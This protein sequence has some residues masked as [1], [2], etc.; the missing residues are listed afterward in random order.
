MNILELFAGSRSIGKVAEQMGMNVFSVDWENYENIDLVKDIE[1]LET[2]DIPFVPDMVWASPDCTSYSIS[3][4]SHHRNGTEPKSDYAKKCDITNQNFIS[5]IKKWLE[6]NPNMVFFIENPRG[7]LRKMPWMQE[8][9]RHTIWYCFSKETK[10]ITDVGSVD[11]KSVENTYQ[12]LLMIDGSWKKCIIRNYGKQ[13]LYKIIFKRAGNEHIIFSTK[14]HKWIIELHSGRRVIVNTIGLKKG[15]RIPTIYSKQNFSH[16]DED[17][18]RSGF[19]YG[20]GYANYKKKGGKKIPYDSVAQFC[21]KKDEELIKFF[22]GLGRSRRYNK[23]YLNISGL[24]FDW[25]K[26]IPNI[27]NYSKEYIVGWLS[28]Y[29]AA[30]GTVGKNGQ[31]TMYSA[32]KNNMDKFKDLCQ[33]VGIGTYFVNEWERDG[34]GKKRKIYSLGL[35]RSTIPDNFILMSHHR[36]NNFTPKFEPHW[37]VFSI[38]ETDRFEDVYCAEVEDYESFV[39]DGNILTHNCKYGDDRAKPT[40]I[41]T[42]SKTWI[43]RPVC[44]NGNPDCHH[45]RAPRGSKTGTQGRKG[46]YERSKIPNELCFEILKSLKNEK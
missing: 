4:I 33:Y 5:L 1:Y 40:D 42:N 6:I 11:I 7:M 27:Y 16:I 14:N 44:K 10:I 21:G 8:F 38:E 41:W 31:V 30:D 15:D 24:P 26:E 9:E 29:F 25:K 36:E 19:V 17:G 2:E 12:N 20:D 22:N 13:R 28:G 18:I 3:A 23:G 37:N 46:S 45:Q 43:P 32:V 34:F 35:I 39:L